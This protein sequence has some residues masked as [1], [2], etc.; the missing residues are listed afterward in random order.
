MNTLMDKAVIL[1]RGLG[2]RM[3]KQD[4]S[5]SISQD[6][7]SVADTGIK[8][9]I[10]IDRPFLD[11]VLHALAESGYKH[12]CLIVGPEQDQLRSYYQD[13]VQLQRLN[14]SFAIQAQPLGTADA[15]LASENFAA[16]DPFLVINSD[17]YYPPQALSSLRELPGPGLAAFNREAM[18]TGG[19]IPADRLT[20]FAVIRTDGRGHMTQ[21]IEKPD[22]SVIAQLPEPVCVSMNCWRFGPSIFTA[23][24]NISPSPRG[25]LEITDAVQYTIENLGETYTAL[26]VNAPVLDLSSRADIASVREKLAGSEVIL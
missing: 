23:C 1:A 20:K 14:L 11:Y 7:A 13:T 5:A 21:I 17:N 19:N 6:E 8:A 9:L 3:R 26:I 4:D 2:T 10:P 18:F 25:E 12:V 24:R 15:V 22:P 16:D